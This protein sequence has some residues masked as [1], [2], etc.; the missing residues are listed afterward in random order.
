MK[1]QLLICACVCVSTIITAQNKKEMQTTI[2]ELQT[3]VQALQ[4][5]IGAQNMTIEAI[6]SQLSDSK[7]TIKEL[8]QSVKALSEK[9]AALEKQLAQQ[10]GSG[11]FVPTTAQD[12]ALDFF[13]KYRNLENWEDLVAHV[14]EPERIKPLMKKY[15]DKNGYGT[16]KLDPVKYQNNIKR[17]KPNLYFIN[18][19]DGYYI[20]KTP[21]GFKVDWEGSMMSRMFDLESFKDTQPIGTITTTWCYI[22]SDGN[23][24]INGYNRYYTGT[25]AYCQKGTVLDQ[26]LQ[27]LVKDGKT[28]AVLKVK[29]STDDNERKCLVITE[30]VGKGWSKYER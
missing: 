2:S 15:Y 27:N 13:I 29:V 9:Q 17:L 21:D 28:K 18:S 1:K 7:S 23:S 4:T 22:S 20:V 5:T 12:S 19:E 26:K 10:P 16:K 3:N 11:V 8:Q 25:F 14:M 24:Y 6:N 30:L